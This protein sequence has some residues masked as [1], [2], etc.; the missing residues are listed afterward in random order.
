MQEE[1]SK[2]A[3]IE[4]ETIY[5]ILRSFPVEQINPVKWIQ[6]PSENEFMDD[7]KSISDDILFARENSLCS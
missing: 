2:E 3:G 4:P 5:D 7:V 6:R 1:K